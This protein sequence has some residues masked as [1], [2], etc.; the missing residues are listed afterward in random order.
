MSMDLL[1]EFWE[2]IR[3]KLHHKITYD[4]PCPEFEIDMSEFTVVDGEEGDYGKITY[5]DKTGVIAVKTVH[6]G[7]DYDVEFT[8]YG[9]AVM[10]GHF[11]TILDNVLRPDKKE[12]EPKKN[13]ME[14]V[15]KDFFK[16]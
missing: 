4:N 10:V 6:G 16:L 12:E 5:R 14:E 3:S 1:E 7:D 8:P 2:D 9:R 13:V 11:L 15:F